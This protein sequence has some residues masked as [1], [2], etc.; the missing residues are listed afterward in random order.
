ME[1]KPGSPEKSVEALRWRDEVLQI[2]YWMHGESFGRELSASDLQKFLSADD[3]VLAE[4]FEQMVSAGLLA[5]VGNGRYTLTGMGHREGGRRFAD[6]FESM[7]K[8]G[9]YECD[10]PE[11]DC[12][13]PEFGGECKRFFESGAEHRHS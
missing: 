5:A 6:E 10:D 4:T 9:H 1:S 7:L 8:P 3:E 13:D 12:H 2:M 11:C